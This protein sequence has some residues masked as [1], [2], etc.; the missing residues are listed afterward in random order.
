FLTQVK[1]TQNVIE[2]IKSKLDIVDIASERIGLK[3]TGSN[4]KGCCPFHS[5][6]T[7][8]FIVN[9]DKQIFHCFGCHVGGDVISFVEKIENISFYEAVVKLAEIANVKLP[10]VERSYEEKKLLDK[11][12]ELVNINIIARDHFISRIKTTGNKAQTYAKL[13]GL[14]EETMKTF[15]IG[16]APEEWDSLATAI[17]KK[18]I[19]LGGA[20]SLGLVKETNGKYYD[21]FRDRIMFPILNNRGD[22]V[23]FGGRILEPKEDSPK[24]INSRESDLYKKGEVL[25]GLYQTSKSIRDMGYA[26]VVEGYMDFISL[27]QAGIRNV[28]ATL[29]TS[30]TDKQVGLIKRYTD[31]IVLFYDSDEAGINAAKRSFVPLLENGLKVDALFLEDEMDPDDAVIKLG[32]EEL[33]SRLKKAKPLMGKIIS[34]KF[35]VEHRIDEVAKITKEILGYIALIPDNV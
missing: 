34:D 26:V 33:E 15:Y 16:Y 20:V 22:V 25:Y 21:T 7:P 27:Y 8:S 23:A 12:Q 11:R 1:I 32:K 13:R 6:K 19:S 31:R 29:G 35:S 14:S 10:T 24:Y 30:F 28:V 4:Y 18:G 2:E 17:T 5:E 9:P 3:K